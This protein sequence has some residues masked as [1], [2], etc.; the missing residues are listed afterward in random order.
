MK[1]NEGNTVWTFNRILHKGAFI[2]SK[3]CTILFSNFCQRVIS[4]KKGFLR[5]Q[6]TGQNFK[7][8]SKFNSIQFNSIYVGF[9]VVR[10]SLFVSCNGVCKSCLSSH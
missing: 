9:E 8:R 5:A 10:V 4:P 6:C 2:W 3:L 7:C 1:R